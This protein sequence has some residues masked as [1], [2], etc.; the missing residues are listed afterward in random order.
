MGLSPSTLFH[1]T[2]MEGL[3]GILKDNFRINYCLEELGHNDRPIKMA[4]PMVSFC[5][6]KISEITEHIGKYGH[7]G[8][9]LSKKW[10]FESGLNPVFYVNIKSTFPNRLISTLRIFNS[11]D[12]ISNYDKDSY[13]NLIR[14]MKIY[15]GELKRD[16]KIIENYRF[17]DEREWRYVPDLNPEKP[18]LGWL[19]ST[20][21]DT[22]LKKENAN[23]KLKNERLYFNANQILYLIVK[24][25][26]EI[27]EIID[28]IRN[29]KSKNYSLN[30]V[31]RLMT[32]I[33]SCERILN[34]F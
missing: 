9:G 17:A 14:Y 24:E 15:E 1:F 30:E 12:S 28:H 11:L 2:S 10:A 6:I 25:E 29:V 13:T 27:E 20:Q 31:E 16:I 7:Y 3:K 5:D 32:R 26:I 8:I 21:Y 18:F 33:I 4:I 23:S 22:E 19:T 34:D